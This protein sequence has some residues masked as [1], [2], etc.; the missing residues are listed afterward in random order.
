M[1]FLEAFIDVSLMDLDFDALNI[2]KIRII[3]ERRNNFIR[4]RRDEILEDAF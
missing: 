1:S 2:K 3:R 4:H